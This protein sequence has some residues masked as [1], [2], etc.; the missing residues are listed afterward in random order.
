MPCSVLFGASFL[1]VC[2]AVGRTVLAPA[3]L[4]AGV[5]TALLGGPGLISMLR[6]QHAE[7]R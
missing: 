6:A 1:A 3:D 4:P 2:D 7:A 5:I